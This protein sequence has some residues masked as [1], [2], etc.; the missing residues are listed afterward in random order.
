MVQV[1][2]TGY[3]AVTPYGLG[4][5]CL[6]DAM[7]ASKSGITVLPK[8]HGLSTKIAGVVP[9]YDASQ[10]FSMKEIRR[11]D[12]FVQYGIL[13]AREAI[14]QAGLLNYP[15]R[16]HKRI[17][18]A[19]GSGIGGIDG[20][21]RECL[22]F[23]RL[24]LRKV[25]PFF[26][27]ATLVNMVAGYTSIEVG[28]QGPNYSNV[29]AC[30]TGAHNII[31]AYQAIKLGMADVMLAGGAEY[32]STSLGM[33]GFAAMRALSTCN[34]E[35]ERA[36]RPWDKD[37]DG[38]VMS[39]GAGVLVLESY[40]HAKRR[41]AKIHAILSGVGMNSD[42]FH[43]TRP[44]PEGMGASVCMQTALADANLSIHDVGYINAHA[45]STPMG[46]ENE[47]KAIKKLFGTKA[48]KIP[49]SSTKSMR[50]EARC[51]NSA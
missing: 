32:G 14:N 47:P 46:D 4:V 21:Q 44:N 9:N 20:I 25:S 22:K 51:S 48:H 12:R 40:T 18:V 6:W 19:I 42:A 15:E 30:A 31:S 23:D 2:V 39:D 50:S 7:L 45:T 29:S 28:F 13:A 24:G 26:V 16:D 3:G 8:D 35:P 38:F 27:P 17:G 33:A 10:H 1:V 36:S 11:Y 41:G 43:M 5:S 34:H 49:V 37:R